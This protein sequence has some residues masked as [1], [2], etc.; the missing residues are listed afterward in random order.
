MTG[1]PFDGFVRPK[2]P[3]ERYLVEI[4]SLVVAVFKEAEGLDVERD[5][6]EVEEGG[7]EE[8]IAVPGPFA[9]G[10][11]V[12]RDGETD[13]L[14]LYRWYE[15]SRDSDHFASSRRSGF[16]ILVDGAGH[17]RMRWKFRTALITAWDGPKKP[18]K[19][20]HS[21]EIEGVEIAHEGLEPVI[22]MR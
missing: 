21:F 13:D 4:A 8:R 6:E 17:E 22:R 15:K 11:F 18:P 1:S 14:E 9:K 10:T 3:H 12:L 5:M 19:P 20:G 7:R 16:V 2:D